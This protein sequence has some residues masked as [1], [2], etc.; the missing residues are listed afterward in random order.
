MT[1]D[2]HR[3]QRVQQEL[4]DNHRAFLAFLE[5]RV[6]SR[7]EAEEILQNA[8][9]RSL[10]KPEQLR[11]DESAV[12]WFYRLLRNALIDRHRRK[13]AETRALESHAREVDEAVDMELRDQVCACVARLVPSLKP[14]YGE[15][16]RAV[17][18]D[19]RPVV[20]VAAELGISP[21]NASVRLHRA[22]K[23]LRD[24]VQESCGSCA[25]HGCVDCTCRHEQAL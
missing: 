18:V 10:G 25:E 15:L 12:A 17:E 21:N 5:R 9:V 16:L 8:F 13:D 22:R 3:H 2:D 6:G 14:E 4:L 23:A 20:E 7:H 19:E 24:K 11:D 1:T